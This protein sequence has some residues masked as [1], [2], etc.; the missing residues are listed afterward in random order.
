MKIALFVHC[1]F[2]TH[3]YGTE[4]YTLQVARQLRSMGHDP[5]VVSAAFPGEP[6]RDSAVTTY[7]YDGLR[8]YCIDKNYIPQRRVKETYYQETIRDTLKGA[9]RYSPRDR[10]R[11]PPDQPHRRPA[12]GRAPACRQSRNADRFLLDSATT[13]G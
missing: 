8:V 7:R 4:T 6:R 1:F 3:F 9:G 12:R 10:S 2:P 5:V 13:I 11:H